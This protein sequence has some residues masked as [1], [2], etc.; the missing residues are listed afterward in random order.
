MPDTGAGHSVGRRRTA[1]TATAAASPASRAPPP[2]SRPVPEVP[3]SASGR[4]AVVTTLSEG[5]GVGD[6]DVGAATEGE[7]L[8][9]LD[10]DADAEGRTL[11]EGDAAVGGVAGAPAGPELAVVRG[12]RGAVVPGV[13]PG[14]LRGAAVVRR[15]VLVG[16]GVDVVGR[17]AAVVRVGCG[18]GA[19]AAG[20]TEGAE[21]DPNRKPTEEPGLGS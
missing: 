1:T 6:D 12:A 16:F 19:G 4:A 5:D 21:P 15:G 9:P 11:R 8:D 3:V 18:A 17:G 2:T 10:G 7:G 14:V 20:L 13:E